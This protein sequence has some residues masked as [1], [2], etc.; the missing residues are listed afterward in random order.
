MRLFIAFDVPSEELIKLQNNFDINGVKLVKEFHLTLKFLGE[1]SEDKINL[2]IDKLNNVKFKSFEAYFDKL[3][4]FPNENYIKVIWIGL[5]PEDK[6]NELREKIEDAL[7]DLFQKEE[8]F[9]A[10]ITLGRV[11]FISDRDK[12]VKG[13][14]SEVIKIKFPVDNFK[15]YKSELRGEGPVYTMVKEFKAS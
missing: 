1:V 10:H 15:V 7:K 9:K 8:R 11:K 6:I 12:I 3:G 13:L 14:K 2:I 4:L 5:Q